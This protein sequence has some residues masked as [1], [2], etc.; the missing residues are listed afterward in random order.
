MRTTKNTKCSE[1]DLGRFWAKVQKTENCWLWLGELV[2]NGYGRFYIHNGIFVAHRMSWIIHNGPI[3]NGLFVCHHCD[4]PPCVRP[5]HLF[6][7][8][9]SDN[10]KDCAAKGRLKSPLLDHHYAL[11]R[12]NQGHPY[13]AENT[14]IDGRGRRTCSICKKARVTRYRR[15][16]VIAKNELG[17]PI[18]SLIKEGR[19]RLGLTQKQLA[20]L[21]STT[22]ERVR[23][24]EK[25]TGLPPS[26]SLL[27]EIAHVLGIKAELLIAARRRVLE[28]ATAREGG[29]AERGHD[30]S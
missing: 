12:C 4:N 29:N 16:A 30:T 7:G 5:D 9:N 10:M 18:G 28:G 8:T 17:N 14:L 25:A 19:Q 21:T 2:G 23:V 27:S 3:P 24:I 22:Y 13:T 11:A 26:E 15:I 20:G 6:L 1:T